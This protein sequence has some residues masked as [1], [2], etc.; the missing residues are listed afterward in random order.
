MATPVSPTLSATEVSDS[1]IYLLSRLLVVR[2][3]QLDFQEGFK[4]NALLPQTW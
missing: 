1:Y 4:W 2:Q 3:Q